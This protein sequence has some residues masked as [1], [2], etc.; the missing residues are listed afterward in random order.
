MALAV[1]RTGTIFKKCDMGD[2]RPETNTRCQAGTCQHTCA[3]IERCPHAWTLRYS[4]NGKQVEKLFRDTVNENTGRT[5]P[6]SG[7]KLAQDFQLKLTVDKRSGDIT[8]AAH[9]NASKASFGSAV[10][11]YI[12]RLSVGDNSKK[13][14]RANYR[15]HIK[16]VF[17]ERTLARVANDRDEVLDLLAVT[18]KDKSLS[19]RT[20]ARLLIVGTVDEAVKAGKLSKHRLADIELADNGTKKNHSDFVFPS[21]GQAKFVADGGINPD[22][23]RAIDGAGICVWLMRGCG[24]RIEEALAV[25]EVRFQGQRLRPPCHVAGHTRWRQESAA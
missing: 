16:P 19:V 18:M 8:F 1:S 7:R 24:L 14:N 22:T 23:K 4:V 9:G 2:H 11:A 25:R 3:N 17:G 13:Q 20:I 10:E 6:A 15:T 21:F 12:S 5:I